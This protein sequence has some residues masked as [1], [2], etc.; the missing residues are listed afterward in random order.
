MDPEEPEDQWATWY[1][2]QY[3]KVEDSV[4]SQTDSFDKGMLTLSSASLGVSL[5]FIKDTVP[6]SQATWV[7]I[8]ELSWVAFSLCIVVTVISFR[9]S[10]CVLK[11][12]RALLD[13]M[14]ETKDRSL[15]Q[16][17]RESRCSRMLTGC[18]YTALTLFLAGLA[19][20]V[21][22][23]VKNVSSSSINGNAKQGEAVTKPCS[24]V[25]NFFMSDTG[26][27]Q[28]V[29]VPDFTRGRH[30]GKLVPPPQKAP[31]NAPAK[32]N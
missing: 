15:A 28:K 11:E 31:A 23:L 13:R 19:F 25:R 14:H 16:S 30:P 12:R 3:D 8:L 24:E 21:I 5:A 32:Q 4:A 7:N 6:L 20:T 18:T 9:V 26:K 2:N 10:I 1:W 17:A 22:F 27:E 29:V